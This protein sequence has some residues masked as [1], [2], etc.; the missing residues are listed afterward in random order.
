MTHS[1]GHWQRQHYTHYAFES[2][3]S[4]SG[5]S[6]Q[7]LNIF[8][9]NCVKRKSKLKGNKNINV[10]NATTDKYIQNNQVPPYWSSTAKKNGVILLLRSISKQCHLYWE[11][12][13]LTIIW[14]FLPP[15]PISSPPPFLPQEHL[16]P[17]P[18]EPPRNMDF[19]HYMFNVILL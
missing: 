3:P 18:S 11:L 1:V 2:S 19:R 5:K 7:H 14:L 4:G 15:S 13:V 8:T 6:S 16:E 12:Q 10:A 17:A 9:Y